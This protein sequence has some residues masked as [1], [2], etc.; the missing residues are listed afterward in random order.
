M[1]YI[2]PQIQGLGSSGT[3]MYYAIE[4]YEEA[5][6]YIENAVTNAHLREISEALCNWNQMMQPESW[7]GLMI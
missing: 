1:W 5:K 7:D 4:D 2:F 3:A 6:A